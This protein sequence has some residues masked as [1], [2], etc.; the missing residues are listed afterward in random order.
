MYAAW[1]SYCEDRY[2]DSNMPTAEGCWQAA[3]DAALTPV[4]D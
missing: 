2:K 4:S 1:V 3:F